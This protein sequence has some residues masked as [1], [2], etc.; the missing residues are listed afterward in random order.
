MTLE[1]FPSGTLTRTPS[2]TAEECMA[3]LSP[4]LRH[5]VREALSGAD[6]QHLDVGDVADLCDRVQGL[7]SF[8]EYQARG[9]ARRRRRPG[10]A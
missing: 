2:T 10:R 6:P 4:V 9:R 3:G 7:I 1:K 5:R 8:T